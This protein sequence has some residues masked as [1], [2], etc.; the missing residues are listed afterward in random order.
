[1]GKFLSATLIL[2]TLAVAVVNGY[3]LNPIVQTVYTADPAPV[4][5]DGVC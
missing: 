4:V 3:A 5:H 2:G 1:M